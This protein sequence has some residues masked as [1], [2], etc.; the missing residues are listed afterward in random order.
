MV[1]YTEILMYVMA[2]VLLLFAKSYCGV[3]SILTCELFRDLAQ[4]LNY[5]SAVVANV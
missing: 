1:W 5:I 3:Q 4:A 2:G